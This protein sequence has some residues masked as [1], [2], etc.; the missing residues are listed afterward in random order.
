MIHWLR[1]VLNV[2]LVE[3]LVLALLTQIFC[4]IKLWRR[5][6]NFDPEWTCYVLFLIAIIDE[7]YLTAQ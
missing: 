6:C 2:F 3:A 4:D 7:H 5:T 1:G